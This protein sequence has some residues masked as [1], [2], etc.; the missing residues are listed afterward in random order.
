MGARI[1]AALLSRTLMR[2]TWLVVV[3]GAVAPLLPVSVILKRTSKLWPRLAAVGVHSTRARPYWGWGVMVMPAGA[4]S[5]E[6]LKV[7]WSRSLALMV[8]PSFWPTRASLSPI[9]DSTGASEAD[10]AVMMKRRV[11]DWA[12][13]GP[14]P[15]PL[16]VAVK[17]IS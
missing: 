4:F 16:S 7:S 2:T 6:K 3:L 8:K 10:A 13:R 14:C 15:S 9:G 17:A 11:S 1:G 12:Y 5:I